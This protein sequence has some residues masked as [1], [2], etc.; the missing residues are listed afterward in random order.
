MPLTQTRRRTR[1][2]GCFVILCAVIFRFFLTGGPARLKQWLNTPQTLAILTYLETGR[3]VR[4]S[5]SEE[6]VSQSLPLFFRESPPPSLPQPS[7]PSFSPEDADFLSLTYSCRLRPDLGALLSRPLSWNL[8]TEDPSVLIL[9]THATESYTQAEE[10]YTESSAYRTTDIDYNM[11]SIGTYLQQLLKEGGITAIHDTALHDY[12]SYSGSYVHARSAMEDYLTR[13]PSIRLVLDL[14]RDALETPGGQLRT[15]VPDSSPPC[16]QLMLVLGT[17]AAGQS[18]DH[19]KENLS[20]GLKLQTQLERQM[21]GITRPLQLRSQR[22]NQDLSNGA[23]L[24]EIGAAGNT[25]QEALAAAEQL[26]QGILALRF[27]SADE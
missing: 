23:L 26:A 12:P 13:Y 15:L 20:L 5:A 6:A 18:H 7:I 27:G 3:Y 1:R 19:W 4:F 10:R 11:V 17:N 8:C 2:F 21:P 16:A 14:H 24:V 22:F 9:H 25:R